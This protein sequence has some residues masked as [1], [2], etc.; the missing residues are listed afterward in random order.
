M[1]YRRIERQVVKSEAR[2]FGHKDRLR[3]EIGATVQIY[4]DL[5]APDD[6]GSNMGYYTTN[7][8]PGRYFSYVSQGLRNTMHS[9]AS[10]ESALFNN[11]AACEAAVAK[12]WV[13]AEKRAAKGSTKA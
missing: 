9:Q 13:Q 7:K 8:G 2:N 5:Y 4:S 3:R 10:H 11:L 1:S 6:G 12:Y